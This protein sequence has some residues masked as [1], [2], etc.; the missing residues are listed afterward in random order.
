MNRLLLAA[1]FCLGPIAIVGASSVLAGPWEEYP[2]VLLDPDRF[3]SSDFKP[4]DRVSL[5][6]GVWKPAPSWD[7]GTTAPYGQATYRLLYGCAAD[8]DDMAIQIQYESTAYRLFLNGREILANGRVGTD[9][10]SSVPQW[11]PRTIPIHLRRGNNTLVLQV[12]NYHSLVGG[13]FRPVILGDANELLQVRYQRDM[14]MLIAVGFFLMMAFFHFLLVAQGRSHREYFIFGLFCLLM[15]MRIFCTEKYLENAF[16][17]ADI[18]GLVLRLGYLSFYGTM[19]VLLALVINISPVSTPRPVYRSLL[20]ITIVA[21]ALA[22]FIPISAL[23]STLIPFQFIYFACSAYI[24]ISSFRS[25]R[26]RI[27]GAGRFFFGFLLMFLVSLNDNIHDVQAVPRF[28]TITYLVPFGVAVFIILQAS[29]LSQIFRDAFNKAERLSEELKN[30]KTGLEDKIR[31]R[32]AELALANER[33]KELDLAKTNFFFNISHELRTPLTLITAPLAGLRA[34]RFGKTVAIGNPI[35]EAMSRNYERLHRQVN[36]LLLFA[37]IEQVKLRALPRL[38]D[39]RELLRVY[40]AELESVAASQG[41]VLCASLGQS[42]CQVSIDVELFEVAFFNLASNALKFTDSGGKVEI[43]CRV[44]GDEALVSIRDNGIGIA[45]DRLDGIF[46]RFGQGDGGAGRHYEGTGIGLSLTKEILVLMGG[47]ISVE[48]ELGSGS[49]FTLRL[50][51]LGLG[52][53]GDPRELARDNDAA[54][55][56]RRKTI[57]T[58]VPV[59]GA[60]GDVLDGPSPPA[61]GGRKKT[62]LLVEDNVDLLDFLYDIFADGYRTLRAKNGVEALALL[63]RDRQ[64]RL[65][66]SDIMMPGMDGK[67]LLRR[68]RGDERHAGLPFIFLTARSSDEEKIECLGSGAVDYLVKPFRPEELLAK[69]EAV[70]AIREEGFK[71]AE[72]RIKGALYGDESSGRGMEAEF[73][74]LGLSESELAVARI[75]VQGKSDKEIALE[76]SCSPKS[77]SNKVA[78]ILR[79]TKTRGRAEFIASLGRG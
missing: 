21:V 38:V 46:E 40:A 45:K 51:R 15:A 34:G 59:R 65:V 1:I 53:A 41:I 28:P 73:A 47:A 42:A 25:L 52:C 16:P 7:Y 77:A 10:G 49:R 44:D 64:I 79:K 9:H 54:A 26:L 19:P 29:I 23:Q 72:R 71:E 55:V 12:S 67:E 30:E 2:G 57:L 68:M 63:D 74:R 60:G 37:K 33:L 61:R 39:L 11:R 22:I 35:F 13:P 32:T 70:L 27:V 75:L 8:S 76:L 48:S 24:L 20:G 56:E 6:P 43:D 5:I 66:V 4:T 36:N 17:E 18:F 50:P 58:D 3:E 62:V 69:A 14:V 78:S 31:S